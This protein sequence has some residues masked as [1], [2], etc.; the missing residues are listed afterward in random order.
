MAAFLLHCGHTEETAVFTQAPLPYAED[1]LTPTIS[2]MTLRFHYGKHHAGYVA[3]ANARIRARRLS[4]T[5]PEQVIAETA[6]RPEYRALFNSAAQ[7]WNH[8]FFWKCLKP[9][10]GQPPTGLLADKIDNAFGSYSQFRSAFIQA[11]TTV[12]GSG[13]IWL[14]A[15]GATLRIVNTANADTPLA[16]GL[17]P[18][19]VV[20]VWEHAYYLDYQNRRDEFVKSIFDHLADWKFA[21]TQLTPAATNKK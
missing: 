9:G 14:V 2:A 5:T 18:L 6:G 12:F 13:W 7:A 21:A 10:G 3:D 11:G 19:F 15:D 16:H 8:D 17:T 4:A 1:A 20:D